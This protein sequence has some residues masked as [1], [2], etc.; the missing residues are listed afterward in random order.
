MMDVPQKMLGKAVTGEP[1]WEKRLTRLVS[2]QPSTREASTEEMFWNLGE[3]SKYQND[4]Q[5]NQSC[6]EFRR[7][8]PNLPSNYAENQIK[9]KMSAISDKIMIQRAGKTMEKEIS[10]C[11]D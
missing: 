5:D 1:K 4:D 6:T 3:P 10:C 9:I 11:N 7:R 2:L 8:I